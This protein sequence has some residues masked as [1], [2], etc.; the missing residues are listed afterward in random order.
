MI[1]L[2][3][4][5]EKENEGAPAAKSVKT[6]VKKTK[7]LISDEEKE[8]GGVSLAKPVRDLAK[9]KHLM[10]DEDTDNVGASRKNFVEAVTKK[11]KLAKQPSQDHPIA[12]VASHEMLPSTP[13]ARL[14]LPDLIGMED[15]RRE[16]KNVTPEERLEWD[17][18]RD[19]SSATQFPG[20]RRVRKRARSSSPIGS[21]PARASAHFATKG[22]S[23]NQQ[24]DPGS[25]LWGRYSTSGSA[26]PTP[27]G[28]P[29]PPSLAHLMQTSSPQ[30]L[31]EG[32]VPRTAGFRRSNSCGNQFPKRRKVEG[33]DVFAGGL[34]IGPSRLS[35]L[36]ERVQEG[37]SQAPKADTKSRS[38]QESSSSENTSSE[39][40]SQTPTHRGHR[41]SDK[42]ASL[43]IDMPG[44]VT[45]RTGEADNLHTI[46]EVQPSRGSS[47]YGDFDD[48]DL[49]EDLLAAVES[50]SEKII[51]EPAF[52]V[53]PDDR[54]QTHAMT[55]G[56]VSFSAHKMPMPPG[57][58]TKQKGRGEFD[59]S[60]DD[61]GMTADLENILSQFDVNSSVKK[62]RISPRKT[63][64][65][66]P[67][68]RESLTIADSDDEFGDG[69]L[70][71]VDF[72][73]AEATATQSIQQSANSLIPVRTRYP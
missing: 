8:N 37:L 23:L 70:D 11:V 5:D 12:P 68:R 21:S 49:D 28:Q 72:D 17:H 66:K 62:A 22:E 58:S 39:N 6:L 47:D 30:T 33:D 44:L 10:S 51:I 65:S 45:I 54:R 43:A 31:K 63:A 42:M 36:I 29:I 59:D 20:L 48:D 60:D 19:M 35:V 18:D 55:K 73:A 56:P 25:D 64:I 1:N 14:A 53:P 40:K 46:A 26:V 41:P 13:A 16:V 61:E 34:A 71:D 2:I 69:D 52:K 50:K 27:R 3:S 32:G 24:V 67:S 38:S 57:P 4:D 9:T 15:I 7:H